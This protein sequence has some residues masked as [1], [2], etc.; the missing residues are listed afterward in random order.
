LVPVCSFRFNFILVV[1]ESLNNLFEFQLIRLE[2][3][4]LLFP[5]RANK[6]RIVSMLL[7]LIDLDGQISLLIFNIIIFLANIIDSFCDLN[8]GGLLVISEFD[9]RVK[10]IREI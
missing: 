4:L 9:L 2:S 8:L 3:K 10:F 6:L 7:H 5:K 1:V